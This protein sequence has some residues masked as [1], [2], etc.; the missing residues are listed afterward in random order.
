LPAVEV[1]RMEDRPRRVAYVPHAALVGWMSEKEILIVEDH[2]LVVYNFETGV[3]RKS[4]VRVG[5]AASVF[6]R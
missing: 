2:L 1:K 6:L 4:G 5:D 3:R